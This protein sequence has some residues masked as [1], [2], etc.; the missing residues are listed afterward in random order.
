MLIMRFY[1]DKVIWFVWEWVEFVL[2]FLKIIL[3]FLIDF[4]FYRV[5]IFS[6]YKNR[7]VILRLKLFL[8]IL[9]VEGG[10]MSKMFYF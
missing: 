3:K 10:N 2:L 7:I 1:L 6:V 4:V 5:M 9:C 8:L